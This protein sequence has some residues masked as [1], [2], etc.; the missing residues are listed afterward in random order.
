MD[1]V[2]QTRVVVVILGQRGHLAA[3]LAQQF[4]VVEGLRA[5][6][7]LGVLAD[8]IREPAQQVPPLGLAQV[9]PSRVEKGLGGRLNRGVDVG[10]VA[11]GGF[12]QH[13]ASSGVDAHEVL[14]GVGLHG[15][16]ADEVLQFAG[17]R[18]GRNLR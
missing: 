18:H 11:A 7:F 16:S 3:H 10:A 13:L 9:P 6:E 17:F 15:F 5:G 12:V 1:L 2:G 8:Q 4:A 14:T